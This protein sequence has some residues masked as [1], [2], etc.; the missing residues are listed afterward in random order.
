[1]RGRLEQDGTKLAFVY[2]ENTE[3]GSAFLAQY[4]V[5]DALQFSD[6]ERALYQVFELERT[7]VWRMFKLSTLW[8]FIKS[9][10]A[11]YGVAFSD[12]DMMQMPGTFLFY[13]GAILQSYR[14]ETVADRPDYCAIVRS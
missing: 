1:V 7:N 4:G 13:N 14:H 2:M 9:M 5:A 3:R 12:V 6:P 8:R 11:G 10:W